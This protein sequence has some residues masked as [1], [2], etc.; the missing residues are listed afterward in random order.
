MFGRVSDADYFIPRS[1]FLFGNMDVGKIRDQCPGGRGIITMISGMGK[2]VRN[3]GLLGEY[4]ILHVFL[5]VRECI[6]AHV[7]T[8]LDQTVWFTINCLVGCV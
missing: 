5:C 8:G 1:F 6:P 4:A 7:G 2:E 3:D